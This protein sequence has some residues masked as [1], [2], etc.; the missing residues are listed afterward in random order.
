MAK[1]PPYRPRRSKTIPPAIHSAAARPFPRA[2]PTYVGRDAEL[3]RA[4]ELLDRETLHLV[5][6]VGGV[7]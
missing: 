5:Y 2:V 3:A 6:G 4:L 1:P 7:G